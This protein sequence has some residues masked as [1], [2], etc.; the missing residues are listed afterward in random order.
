MSKLIVSGIAVAAVAFMAIGAAVSAN[1][2]ANSFEQTIIAQHDQSENVLGQY[3][4]KLAEQIGVTKLQTAAVKDIF[5]SANQARY[6]ANGSQATMQWLVEQNPNFDQS[7]YRF[8]L[9]TIE[10]G[11]TD[12]QNE[13]KTKIDQ[14][15]TYR[16]ALGHF[17]GGMMMKIMGWPSDGFFEKYGEIVVSDHAAKA[18]ETGRDNGLDISK[19]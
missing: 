9:E 15:R 18:F 16:T 11:R 12:F 19:M 13:Q 2:T 8:V 17:P 10:A 4:P 1:N 6:G 3:A 14:V 7:N 5:T